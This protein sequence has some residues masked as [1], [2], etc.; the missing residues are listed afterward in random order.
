MSNRRDFMRNSAIGLG[1]A[2]VFTRPAA[3]WGF[4][5]KTVTDDVLDLKDGFR[6]KVISRSG[7]TMSDGYRTPALPDGMGCFAGEPGRYVL[8]RN[9]EIDLLDTASGP[10]QPGQR[11]PA[12]AYDKGGMGGVTRLVVNA[13]SL[14]VE[15]DNLVLIGTARNCGGGMSPWGWLTCEET[16]SENHGYVFLCDTQQHRV[17]EARKIAAYG[18][19][20]HEAA[21]VDSRTNI[22]Y[23]TEDRSD[24]CFYRF[25]PERPG[26]PFTGR[27]Q[28][29]RITGRDRMNTGRDQKT[30]QE[31]TCSWVDIREPDPRTDSVRT[32]G[33]ALGAAMFVRGEG[34]W[35][36]GEYV[37]FSC[38]SGGPAAAGQ[39]FR[40]STGNQ[41]LKLLAQSESRQQLDMPDNIT[42]LDGRVYM[43]EDG[44]ADQYIR[45]LKS[46]GSIVDL[47]RNKISRSEFA[48]LCF[49]PDGKILFANI[50]KDGLTLAITGPFQTI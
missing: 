49:S 5:S 45:V 8:M 13:E 6:C 46:D 17:T 4:F 3:G 44:N 30:G 35:I 15:S 22:C 33:H 27:L 48:G 16:M 28:A 36:E 37:Y 9:H 24:G 47:A 39:I 50:Q 29:L 43:A 19:F 41:T 21:V 38:T 40:Y 2:S 18:R 26:D 12:Q 11:P 20:N 10:Y 23:L 14:Q 7:S 1:L 31:W 34:L 42:V 32:Q 25:V